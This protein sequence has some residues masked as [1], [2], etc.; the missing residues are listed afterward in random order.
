MGGKGGGRFKTGQV[1]CKALKILLG[2][3]VCSSLRWLFLVN[4]A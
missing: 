4:S 3:I 1:F 2:D